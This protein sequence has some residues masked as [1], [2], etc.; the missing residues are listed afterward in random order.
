MDNIQQ[1]NYNMDSEYNIMITN[2]SI[3][4]NKSKVNGN[5]YCFDGVPDLINGT[6]TNEAPIIGLQK[7]LQDKSGNLDKIIMIAS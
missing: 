7:L 5:L 6:I 3:L 2:V 1:E 4:K